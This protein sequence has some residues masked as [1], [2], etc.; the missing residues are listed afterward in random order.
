MKN[1]YSAIWCHQ[2]YLLLKMWT[3][4]HSF[5]LCFAS[6]SDQHFSRSLTGVSTFAVCSFY[7]NFITKLHTILLGWPLKS[8]PKSFP[9]IFSIC[10]RQKKKK[11]MRKLKYRFWFIYVYFKKVSWYTFLK[12]VF[13][14]CNL[15]LEYLCPIEKEIKNVIFFNFFFFFLDWKQLKATPLD[16]LISSVLSGSRKSSIQYYVTADITVVHEI[17]SSTGTPHKHIFSGTPWFHAISQ[18]F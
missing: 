7:P 12:K 18:T 5:C 2:K 9:D 10:F 13:H 3:K 1:K 16:P 4:I 8:S 15:H 17:F 11:T 14:F 6:Y